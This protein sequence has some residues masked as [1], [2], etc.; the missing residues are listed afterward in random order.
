VSEIRVDNSTE[1]VND[2]AIVEYVLSGFA[3][4]QQARATDTRW[5]NIISSGGAPRWIIPGVGSKALPVLSSWKPYSAKSR[6]QWNI[7]LA[8]CRLN[9]LSRLPGVAHI[10]VKHDLSYWHQWLNGFSDS[11]NMVVYVGNPSPTRKAIVF[12]VDET[13][14][15]T[16]VARIPIKAAGKEA[17]LNEANVL[18]RLQTKLPVPRVLFA[19]EERGIAAQ[20]WVAGKQVSRKFTEKHLALLTQL[21][22]PGVT[23]RLMDQRDP[24]EALAKSLNLPIEASLLEKSLSALELKDELPSFIEHRDFA[25]W[26][27]KLLPDGNLTLIDWEWA[28]EESLPWQDICRYFYIQGYLFN[29]SEYIWGILTSNPRLQAYKRRFGLSSEAIHGLTVH[30]LLRALCEDWADGHDRAAYSALQLQAI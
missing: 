23:V 27:I 5:V 12:F 11:W 30:Y 21:A 14:T 17:I 26:N 29:K 25:P 10:S 22:N 16:A 7:I 20:S 9:S 18:R 13:A 2:E 28:I 1:P 4:G 15:V 19:D 24:L 3:G 8:A 6:L